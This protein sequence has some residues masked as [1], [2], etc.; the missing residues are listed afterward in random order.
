[1]W[2]AR[3]CWIWD[4]PDKHHRNK[5][6]WELSVGHW[7]IS[8]V[9]STMTLKF[10]FSNPQIRNIVFYLPS[11]EVQLFFSLSQIHCLLW[12]LKYLFRQTSLSLSLSLSLN[13]QRLQP[14]QSLWLLKIGFIKEMNAQFSPFFPSS[15][16]AKPKYQIAF[17]GKVN[18]YLGW[19]ETGE[20]GR[21]K[22]ALALSISYSISSLINPTT[23]VFF[24]T[25]HAWVEKI[26]LREPNIEPQQ[27]FAC[28]FKQS[29]VKYTQVLD[30]STCTP[31]CLVFNTW[32]CYP[33]YQEG[34]FENKVTL[35]WWLLGS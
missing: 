24:S 12:L 29:R 32:V 2:G 6:S 31:S 4:F 27:W 7:V 19:G 3:R 1:M 14:R 15:I 22:A 35:P 28:G 20:Q 11:G 30:S 13:L 10:H 16:S 9:M 33:V 8:S 17:K 18:V 5:C 34:T 26:K 21:R 25:T 23:N